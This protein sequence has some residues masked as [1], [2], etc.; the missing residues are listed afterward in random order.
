MAI[1]S[2]TIVLLPKDLL[3]RSTSHVENRDREQT[4]VPSMTAL[5][6]RV[7]AADATMEGSRASP[8]SK[9]CMPVFIQQM[10]QELLPLGDVWLFIRLSVITETTLTA[11][12][13]TSER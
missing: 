6:P 5:Y 13:E 3:S 9:P 10:T 7:E 8:R 4:Y 2:S 11:H 1:F 12:V